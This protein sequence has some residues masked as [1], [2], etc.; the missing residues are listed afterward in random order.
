MSAASWHNFS[1]LAGG[2]Q[3]EQCDQ[4]VSA[5]EKQ[6]VT[7]TMDRTLFI[8]SIATNFNLI[9]GGEIW[10]A[11]LLCVHRRHL[12]EGASPVRSQMAAASFSLEHS[13]RMSQGNVDGQKAAAYR[14]S[15]AQEEQLEA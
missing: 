3:S 14:T 6:I 5:G 1:T 4:S 2:P 13:N 12:A 9:L 11:C 8:E 10:E 7:R 15:L